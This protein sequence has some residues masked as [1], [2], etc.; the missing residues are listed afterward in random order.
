M[1]AYP[2]SP[3]EYAELIEAFNNLSV[4]AFKGMVRYLHA[5]LTEY[6]ATTFV[7]KEDVEEALEAWISVTKSEMCAEPSQQT[8]PSRRQTILVRKDTKNEDST[9]DCPDVSRL[10]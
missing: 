7:T 8:K 10:P 5:H 6:N 9:G 4:A 3:L 2:F 1:P